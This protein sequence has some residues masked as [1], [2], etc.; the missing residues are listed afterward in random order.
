[1]IH[2]I[3]T[4]LSPDDK[5]A[6]GDVGAQPPISGGG[7]EYELIN[8]DGEVLDTVCAPTHRSA[9]VHF[10]NKTW[11]DTPRFRTHSLGVPVGV[12][13]VVIDAVESGCFCTCASQCDD[14]GCD[15]RAFELARKYV[16]AYERKSVASHPPSVRV[17]HG[18]EVSTFTPTLK[19]IEN[20]T[21][22]DVRDGLV[23]R[24]EIR[25]S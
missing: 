10:I 13:D 23:A 3:P 14:P 20:P 4:S 17:R 12:R 7:A 9:G 24:M 5:I 18:G 15:T 1:M 2:W 16:A 25:V 6:V 22:D 11:S 19:M 8:S 21:V